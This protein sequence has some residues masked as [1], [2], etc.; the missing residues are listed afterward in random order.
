MITPEERAASNYPK[1]PWRLLAAMVLDE[2]KVLP[3]TRGI[4]LLC[5]NLAQAYR[6]GCEDQQKLDRAAASGETE[7]K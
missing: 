7:Q 4:A 3:E 1:S 6:Q 2:A 5:N